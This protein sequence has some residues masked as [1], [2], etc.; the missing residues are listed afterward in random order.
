MR[1]I[2]ADVERWM[3]EGKPV[4]I[5][6]VVQ[7]WGSAPRGVGS[8][9]ALAVDLESTDDATAQMSGSVSGGCVEGA[10]F[11]AG[12]EVLA[13]GMPQLLHFGV[14]DETAWEVGLPCGGTIEIFV[15]VLSPA[16]LHF[17]RYVAAEERAAV[18]ATIIRGDA[19]VL[20]KKLMLAESGAAFGDDLDSQ[21]GGLVSFVLPLMK[22]ALRSGVSARHTLQPATGQAELEIF[23]EAMLPL[24]QLICVGGGHIAIALTQ[25]AK[26]VGYR[27]VVIDPRSAFA[28]PARFSHIDQLVAQWPQDVLTD[29]LLSR[30]TAVAVLTHD[31]KI[32]DKALV[33]VL[34]SDAFYIGAL[35]SKK[36]HAQRLIRLKDAGFAD[37]QLARIHAPIGL[38]ISA[39]TPEE[40]A[41]AVMAQI[42]AAWHAKL[43]TND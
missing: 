42:V 33:S 10:T 8:K 13:S 26:V 24:P 5:A 41:L 19:S 21:I 14:A 18:V 12:S 28:S 17:W 32:D 40:I 22:D 38:N 9:M 15:E 31:P 6:T 11:E 35:G 29:D 4:A 27:T 2:L 25:I 20:G 3:N 30:N 43:I 1:E 7:T 34:Q 37:A 23:I 39:Q 16:L 36:T